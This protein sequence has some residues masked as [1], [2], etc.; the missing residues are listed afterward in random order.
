MNLG[1]DPADRVVRYTLEGT[2]FALRL[3]GTAAKNFAVFVA[4]VL[5]DQKKTRGKTNLARLLREGKPLKF[6]SVP[7]DRM[8]EF[9]QEAKRH[10][11]LFVPMRDCNDPDHIEIAIWAE[12]SAKVERIIDRMQLD[13]LGLRS[14]GPQLSISETGERSKEGPRGAFHHPSGFAL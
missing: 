2:E 1:S 10:G 11:L 3:S 12:D 9:A 6:F 13:V 5:R 8:R 14:V 7:A 4:A